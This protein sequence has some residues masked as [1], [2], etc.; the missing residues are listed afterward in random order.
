[1]R[2]GNNTSYYTLIVIWQNY[3]RF[4]YTYIPITKF[5]EYVE[6]REEKSK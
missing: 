1:M 5:F 3:V 4:M 6:I 2:I